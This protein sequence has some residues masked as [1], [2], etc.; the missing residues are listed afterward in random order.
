MIRS[1]TRDLMV[2]TLWPDLYFNFF[3]EG[4]GSFYGT[5]GGPIKDLDPTKP[6][7]RAISK[8]PAEKSNFKV[9]PSRKGTGYG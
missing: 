8:P 4:R 1:L 6:K 5:L 3:R 7:Y 9:N 2:K